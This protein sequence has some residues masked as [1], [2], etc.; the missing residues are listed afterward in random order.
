MQI[1]RVGV[2]GAGTMGNGIAQVFAQSGFEVRLVDVDGPALARA[3]QCGTVDVDQAY[4]ESRLREHL[5][6]AISHR[7]GANY[8][9]PT[10]LHPCSLARAPAPEPPATTG[11]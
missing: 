5:R 9:D 2:I 6:D 10:D 1:R 7:P 11:G 4:F 3:L 8:P